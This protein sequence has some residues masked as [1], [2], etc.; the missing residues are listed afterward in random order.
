MDIVI[1]SL[2]GG[3][4]YLSTT[5]PGLAQIAAQLAEA[6]VDVVWGHGAH[7][8]QP[9]S[10][11][12]GDRPTVVATSLGNFLFDQAGTDRT[13]GYMLE[14]MVDEVGVVSYRVGVTGHPDRR[15]EFREWLDP[16]GDTA[17]LDGSWWSLTRDPATSPSTAAT[18]SEFRHGDLLAAAAG[19]VDGDGNDEVVA[20]FRRPYRATPFMETH[21]EVQWADSAGRSAHLGVYKPEGLKEVWVAGSVLQPIA[22]LGGVR[23]VTG[24]CS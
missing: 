8:V 2:H 5:D 20:S 3:T 16:T 10:A 24:R 23:R 9:V 15:V 1:V 19:D 12:D 22:G 4:E 11:I 21:P 18:L 6:G 7:V 14:V 13:T 17:W